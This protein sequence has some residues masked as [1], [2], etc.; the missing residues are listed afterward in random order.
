MSFSL[1]QMFGQ[2]GIPAMVVATILL[3]M[4]LGSLTVFIERV[5][6]LRRSRNAARHLAVK[7]RGDLQSGN[8][9]RVL[10]E[11]E[12]DVRPHLARVIRAGIATYRHARSTT[13][14]SGLSPVERTQRHMERFMVAI[15]ADL[16]RGLPL[17]ASVGST[18]PFVG[19][20]GTVL[21]IISAFQGIAATGSGGLSSVS[22]GISEALVETALG[23]SVAIPAVLAFNYLT[24][25]IIHDEMVLN[26]AAG[27]LLD[28]IEDWAERGAQ[29]AMPH[30]EPPAGQSRSAAALQPA[31]ERAQQA[32]VPA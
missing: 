8:L 9:D 32:Q 12:K 27:E 11:V 30:T 28:T 1:S 6:T 16:R 5:V 31:V 25:Q 14:V 26:G 19:L 13:D 4:G 22:A 2:L 10:A 15:A 20:L 29:F 23:L 24:G 18:A 3:L 7:I 21:G 17:L